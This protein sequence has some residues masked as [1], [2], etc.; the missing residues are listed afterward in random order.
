MPSTRDRDR[1]RRAR[2]RLRALLVVV[3]ACVLALAVVSLYVHHA[4]DAGAAKASA[5]KQHGR[6]HRH[7]VARPVHFV[8]HPRPVPILVYH[9]VLARLAGPPLMYVSPS[10]FATSSGGSGTTATRR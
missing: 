6:R 5:G 10:K 2:Y 3:F 8:A 7:S 9:H 4:G 1:R